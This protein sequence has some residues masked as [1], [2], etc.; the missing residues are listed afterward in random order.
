MYIIIK[1]ST[2]PIIP[3]DLDIK[4]VG[5]ALLFDVDDRT[6][7]KDGYLYLLL[8][9][10][11]GA[12]IQDG[13]YMLDVD[14]KDFIEYYKFLKYRTDFEV[15]EDLFDFM[16]HPNV[17]HYPLDFW[18]VKLLDDRIRN[19]WYE[20]KKD[21]YYRLVELIV[22][23][24]SRVNEVLSCIPGTLPSNHYI[25]G[26]AAL[27]IA[28]VTNKFKDIDIFS[29]DKNE[30][31]EYIKRELAPDYDGVYHSG[32]AIT[33]RSKVAI[34]L[35]L[36][37]YSSPSQIV[38]GFDIGCC[39]ILFD[40]KK[41]WATNKALYCI[42]EMVNWFEPDRSSPTY[43]MR[44]AKYHTRGFILKLPSTEELGIDDGYIEKMENRI[45]S[46]YY[47]NELDVELIDYNQANNIYL[48]RDD[49]IDTYNKFNIDYDREFISILNRQSNAVDPE[50]L[51]RALEDPTN[52]NMSYEKI[53]YDIYQS[54]NTVRYVDL[55]NGVEQ[56]ASDDSYLFIGKY[57]KIHISS[58]PL[59]NPAASA[60]YILY[61]N[62]SYDKSKLVPS[63][64][65]SI[66]ILTS[67]FGYLPS[68]I[69][70]HKISD[71]EA[72]ST[73]KH[74][75]NIDKIKWYEN[76]PMDQNTNLT[77]T[78]YPEPILD[79]VREFYKSSPLVLPYSDLPIT[80]RRWYKKRHI[81]NI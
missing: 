17:L 25:A 38:H 30:S 60:L 32:N 7:P 18:K 48:N 6:L 54:P 40:G 63:D 22:E 37:E 62:R 13:S 9:S 1:Y 78:F 75:T 64:P 49:I 23:D 70:K 21:K 65:M 69:I 28:G 55:I 12:D 10:G 77:G 27:Y 58:D 34:Q 80:P 14:P 4:I 61:K 66:L 41:L 76:D 35:I 11:I 79:D 39:S 74:V 19:T 53:V 51:I 71:Y 43:A 44:L 31:I 16:G 72:G 50:V 81:Y 68:T 46:R 33:F 73:S 20:F 42:D 57:A 67:M 56:I 5:N 59:A 15:R 8:N 2:L 24:Q 45:L 36:R 29:C 3:K 47:G 52:S 26:G